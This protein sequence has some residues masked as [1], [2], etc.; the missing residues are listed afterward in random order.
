MSI[1]DSSGKHGRPRLTLTPEE[2][3]QRLAHRRR[4]LADAQARR[5]KRLVDAAADAAEVKEQAAREVAALRLQILHLENSFADRV[6]DL[7]TAEE[8]IRELE[9]KVRAKPK[10]VPRDPAPPPGR[11]ELIVKEMAHSY[12]GEEWSV[13]HLDAY[14]QLAAKFTAEA[15]SIAT[16]VEK[17]LGVAIG[18]RAYEGKASAVR[19]S[20][21][22]LSSEEEDTL[23][24]A[25]QVLYRFA[26]DVDRASDCMKALHKQ[27][28]AEE[29]Q[30][31]KAAGEAIAQ[32]FG[33]LP[34]D[35]KILLVAGEHTRRDYG[36]GD[37]RDLVEGIRKPVER[38][39]WWKAGEHFSKAYR[40]WQLAAA[41]KVAERMKTTGR[42]AMDLV[43]EALGKFHET[44]P[45]IEA[46]WP[47]LVSQVKAQLVIEQLQ[48]T[49]PPS[50]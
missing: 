24:S 19:F 47:D 12:S 39:R 32:V 34:M 18:L 36:W 25:M 14:A 42:E 8:R 50:A 23:R 5:R 22:L 7:T 16:T 28:D 4:Q 48:R 13:W 20:V 44:R 1:D 27:R 46:E 33:G 41:R 9:A 11:V 29:K 15:K 40:D 3:A 45:K 30:R 35:E 31:L 43:A 38:S 37:F 21:G 49:A 2:E 17:I 26:H 6:D 10:A